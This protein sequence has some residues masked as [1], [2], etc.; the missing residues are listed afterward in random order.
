MK[1]EEALRT[2]PPDAAEVVVEGG[3]SRIFLNALGF[4]DL[5][6]IPGFKIGNLAVDHAA[7][8]NTGEDIF[9]HSGNNPCLYMEVKGRSENLGD[10]I[11]PSYRKAA[12]QLKRYLLAPTSKSVEWGILTN[13]I[14]V[15]LFRKHGKIVHPVTPCLSLMEDSKGVIKQ[16]KKHIDNPRRALTVAVY[17]NKGGVGKTTTTLNLAATLTLFKKRVL[18]IDFDPNQSDLGDALN[19]RPLD[20]KVLEVLK[21]KDASAR[22]IITQY[23]FEHPSLK[24]PWSFDIIL[25][26]AKMAGEIDEAKL[27]QH[28]KLHDL[29][30]T[31][32]SIENEY[33]YILIDSPPNWRIFAQKALYAADVV[34]IPARHDNLHSLQNAGT[35]IT[36]FIPQIQKERQRGG[37]AGPVALPI[38]MN[39]VFRET[40]YQIQ[41]MHGAIAKIIKETRKTSGGFDLTHYFYPKYRPGHK[42]LRMISIPYMAYI[43]RADFMHLPAAFAFK[44]ARDQYKNLVKEYFL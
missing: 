4:G 23:K 19:L 8:K 17:N 25:A 3:F 43:S 24:E 34:L 16:L 11:C 5:E 27:K 28:I 38:F 35:A 42:D 10:D 1:L 18:I 26:D 14:H 21:R 29:R 7:R 32:E 20:G 39:N 12:H 22:E 44:P 31:L 2:L 30:R 13:S 6:M 40:E 15:Q 41:L 9:L 33:D 37:E 36:Y